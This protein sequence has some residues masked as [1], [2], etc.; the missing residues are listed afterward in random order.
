MPK[1][2][3]AQ[4]LTFIKNKK[5]YSKKERKTLMNYFKNKVKSYS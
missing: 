3:L 4:Y 5:N 1:N 2:T